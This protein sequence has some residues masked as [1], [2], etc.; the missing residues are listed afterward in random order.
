[1]GGEHVRITQLMSADVDPH[2][3]K[4]VP[5][6]MIALR[7]ADLVL[8][9]GLH[10]EGK[11]SDVFHDLEKEKKKVVA[12]AEQL[13]KSALLID[14]IEKA[15]D[16]H[17]WFDVSLWNQARAVV[18]QA[19]VDAVPAHAET[20]KKKSA[21]YKAKLDELHQYAREQIQTIPK[22]QRVLIT[23][24]DAFRYFGKAYDIEVKGIKGISTDSE[25]SLKTI[26]E[27]VDFITENKIKAVFAESTV[28]K[29]EVTALVEGCGKRGHTVVIGGELFSDAMGQ[30]GTPEGTY[31]GMVRHNVDTIVKAL[32]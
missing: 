14:E 23:A 32:K 22:K 31:V 11:M 1:V 26:S 4:A 3:Y 29:Q 2:L 13:D 6:D 16:P 19:L 10:L 27:L 7:E 20:F 17:V 30:E 8:Y 28:N 18:E 21:A 12:V 24:H 15:P 9:S 25:A 5:S